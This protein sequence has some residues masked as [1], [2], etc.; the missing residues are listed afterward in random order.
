[1]L[2]S[3]RCSASARA[4]HPRIQRKAAPLAKRTRTRQAARSMDSKTRTRCSGH[5]TATCQ[6][7]QD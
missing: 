1:M 4:Y 2:R 5:C 3:D 6:P 7:A